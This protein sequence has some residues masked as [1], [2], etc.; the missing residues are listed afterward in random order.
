M[1]RKECLGSLNR[2]IFIVISGLM[3]QIS[4]FPLRY[5]YSGA[6]IRYAPAQTQHAKILQFI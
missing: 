3:L 1:D 2:Y 5:A 4:A 6:L